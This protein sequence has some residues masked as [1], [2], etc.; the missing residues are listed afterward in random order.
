MKA[1]IKKKEKK[2]YRLTITITLSLQHYP[3]QGF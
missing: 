3:T 1:I 2:C